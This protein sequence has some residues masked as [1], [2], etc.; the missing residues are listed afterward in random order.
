MSVPIEPPAG[1][2]ERPVQVSLGFGYLVE[3]SQ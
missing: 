2:F 3:F 1:G